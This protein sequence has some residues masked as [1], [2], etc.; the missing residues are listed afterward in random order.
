MI[1]VEHFSRCWSCCRPRRPGTYA[2]HSNM[3]VLGRFGACAKVITDL[4]HGRVWCHVGTRL[5]RP[6]QHRPIT[7]MPTMRPQKVPSLVLCTGVEWSTKPW[8]TMRKLTSCF[9]ARRSETATW[10]G[11][12]WKATAF[13]SL[14]EGSVVWRHGAPYGSR[15]FGP[16]TS[17]R[18]WM[19][20]P[21]NC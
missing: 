1:C 19:T 12:H 7:H 2:M 13:A 16:S 18:S 5:H 3:A 11:Q 4:V 21:Y 14:S 20:A 15:G 8:S 10:R 6:L 17:Q 9:R